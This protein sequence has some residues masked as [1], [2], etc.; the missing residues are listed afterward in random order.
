VGLGP[1][2]WPGA[3]QAAY[4]GGTAD[5]PADLLQDFLDAIA[6]GRLKVPIHRTYSHVAV[7]P[8]PGKPNT[9]PAPEVRRRSLVN[10]SATVRGEVIELA[11][12]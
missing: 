5:L 7:S 4:R 10:H 12:R 8:V 6:A 1:H 11:D 3:F 9:W 2:G